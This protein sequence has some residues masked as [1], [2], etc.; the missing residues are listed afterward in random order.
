MVY[1]RRWKAGTAKWYHY[2]LGIPLAVIFIPLDVFLNM[3]VGSVIFIELP[4][5]WIFTTRLD[6][7]ARSGSKFAKFVCK[8]ILNPFD[9]DHCY[10]GS[11]E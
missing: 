10:G 7:H 6:R 8:Y 1:Y 5:E 2:V 9:K 4:K 11:C 3:I